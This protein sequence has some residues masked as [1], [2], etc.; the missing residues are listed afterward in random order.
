VI[1]GAAVM[2]RVRDERDR[3]SGFVV[4]AVE[5]LPA[6]DKIRGTATFLDNH[7]L[8]VDDHT[9]LHAQNV[10]IA[11]G[12]RPTYPEFFNQ[13][14]DRLVVNEEVVVTCCPGRYRRK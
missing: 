4:E 10:V 8:Q 5:E 1:K 3:F 2:K 11:S 13:A 6:Q 7:R 12:S 9:L 14:G